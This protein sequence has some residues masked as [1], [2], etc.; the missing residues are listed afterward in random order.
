MYCRIRDGI[1]HILNISHLGNVYIQANQPWKLVKGSAD[2]KLVIKYLVI[3]FYLC[4]IICSLLIMLL[5]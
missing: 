5:K 2:E 3:T 4:N 1:K